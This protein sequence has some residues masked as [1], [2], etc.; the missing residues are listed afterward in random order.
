MLRLLLPMR[1]SCPRRRLH[2]L[3]LGLLRHIRVPI[4][5]RRRLVRRLLLRRIRLVLRQMLVIR[6]R[7]LVRPLALRLLRHQPAVRP[8]RVRLRGRGR[9]GRS[10]RCGCLRR[11]VQMTRWL[12]ALFS[13]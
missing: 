3:L 12:E 11:T 7:V 1:L 6:R 9:L 13:V 2:L 8:L 10:V 4:H 5:I